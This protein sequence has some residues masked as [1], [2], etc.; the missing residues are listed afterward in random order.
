MSARIFYT[1]TFELREGVYRNYM[2]DEQNQSVPLQEFTNFIFLFFHCH[3]ETYVLRAAS[4]VF[5]RISLV[6]Y[7]K[8]LLECKD[9]KLVLSLKSLTKARISKCSY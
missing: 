4:W 5:D 9:K 1:S 2:T 6:I 8:A 7:L 3:A